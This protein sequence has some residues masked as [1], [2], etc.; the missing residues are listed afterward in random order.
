[1]PQPHTIRFR[2]EDGAPTPGTGEEAE[3]LDDTSAETLTTDTESGPPATIP[4][5]RFKEVND[6]LASLRPFKDL[7]SAGYDADS[8]RQLAEFEAAFRADPVTTWFHIAKD[9]QGLPDEVR[10]VIQQHFT[11]GAPTSPTPATA[12]TAETPDGGIPEWAKPLLQT[13]G[14]LAE[15]DREREQQRISETNQ[16]TLD[17]ILARWHQADEKDEIK[18]TSE[19]R[20][21]TYIMAAANG[22]GSDEE[23][24]D[25]ARG[26]WL[27][28]RDFV[29]SSAVTRPGEGGRS[30]LTVPGGGAPPNV[31][32][33]PRTLAEASARAK[34]FLEQRSREQQ[35]AVR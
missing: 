32:D 33:R 11:D 3:P 34:Q 4:Y 24:L 13:V 35:G 30:P 8:L 10:T 28:E 14:S 2:Y 9:I 21:L 15:R 22:A 27:A 29:L 7:A 6:Q 1:M 31:P 25:R 18:S 20:M 26:E 23:I 12:P 16:R 17:D 5:S 19:E